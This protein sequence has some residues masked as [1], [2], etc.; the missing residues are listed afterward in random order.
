MR[1]LYY[2]TL[3]I[4]VSQADQVVYFSSLRQEILLIGLIF[5]LKFMRFMRLFNLDEVTIWPPALLQSLSS[6]VICKFLLEC[7]DFRKWKIAFSRHISAENE[8][9]RQSQLVFLF[10]KSD[11][12]VDNVLFLGRLWCQTMKMK[13]DISHTTQFSVF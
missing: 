12:V 6:S 13:N 8:A 10:P 7:F 2:P 9:M 4:S 5:A 1:E 11:F 3:S